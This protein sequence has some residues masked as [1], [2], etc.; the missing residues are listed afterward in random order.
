[1]PPVIHS[2]IGRRNDK[3]PVKT[4]PTHHSVRNS[5]G[6]RKIISRIDVGEEK[7]SRILHQRRSE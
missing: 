2:I 4:E 5:I 6:Y 7:I 1:L 3:S